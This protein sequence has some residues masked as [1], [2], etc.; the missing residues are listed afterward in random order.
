MSPPLYL[1]LQGEDG[2]P[3]AKGEMGVKGDMGDNGAP[4]PRGEDGPEGPKGQ[5]GPQGDPGASGI[6][7]EKVHSRL[8][9]PTHFVP[10]VLVEHFALNIKF[11]FFLGET[12]SS[13]FTRIS[14]STRAKGRKNK[15]VLIES[16]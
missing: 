14:R 11:N 10:N 3:G 9:M 6:S 1:H 2:F 5:L 15:K 16:K 4:G 12:R 7:G 8:K 13:R